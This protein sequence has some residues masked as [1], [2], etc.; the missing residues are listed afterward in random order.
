MAKIIGVDL[1]TANTLIYMKGK[2]IVLRAPSVAAVDKASREIVALGREAKLMLGKTPDGIIALRPVKDGV[3]A[4]VEICS[5]M[6]RAY[7]EATESIALFSR[8][9]VIVCIPYGV[10]EVEKNA[11]ETAVYEAGAR[12]V[13]M[14]YEP[15][16]AALGAGIRIDGTRGRMIVDIGGGTAE[17]SVISGGKIIT[18]ETLRVAGDTFDESI[19]KYLRARADILIG[20]ATAEEL[21]LK[22]GSAHP[23]FDKGRSLQVFGRSLRSGLASS[24][25]VAA[26]DVRAAIT[27]DLE[28][29]AGAITET[30][31]R[32]TPELASDVYDFG[33]TMTGGVAYLPGIGALIHERT[34][35][36]IEFAKRPFESV[37]IGIGRIIES[38]SVPEE[39]LQFRS[40]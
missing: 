16:A 26:A 9:S 27:P 22:I 4:D 30:L 6:L 1:G 39:L 29:I 31:S 15:L 10:T 18:S 28:K 34:G 33:I 35:V 5:K 12:S 20:D 25:V 21:K 3:V 32:L 19:I 40:R 11:V 2:N 17:V 23:S 14:I 8:P 36:K 38:E 24:A 7:F 37:C 13:A